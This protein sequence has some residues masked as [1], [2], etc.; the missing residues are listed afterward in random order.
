MLNWLQWLRSLIKAPEKYVIT[1]EGNVGRLE[2]KN[3]ETYSATVSFGAFDGQGKWKPS[4]EIQISLSNIKGYI[5]KKECA[6]HLSE[7]YSS[8]NKHK[9]LY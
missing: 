3:W 1:T 8:K 5:T 7:R 9:S 4:K 2:T 6:S